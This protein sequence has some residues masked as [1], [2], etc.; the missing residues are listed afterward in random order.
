MYFAALFAADGR[1][2]ALVVVGHQEVGP[3][4][5]TFVM[6]GLEHSSSL[7]IE[8]EGAHSVHSL[9]APPGQ[10]ERDKCRLANMDL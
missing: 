6:P 4:P 2:A 10:G 9:D 5:A 8:G 1:P 7:V 3:G